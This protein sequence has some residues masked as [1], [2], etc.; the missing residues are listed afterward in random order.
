MARADRIW[1]QFDGRVG[2]TYLDVTLPRWIRALSPL[3]NLTARISASMHAKLLGGFLVVA[4][5]LVGMGLL[6]LGTIEQ[7]NQR[8]QE[9]RRLQDDV[10]RAHQMLYDTTAQMHYRAM[11]LLNA[12]VRHIPWDNED[13]QKIVKAKREFLTNLNY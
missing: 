13:I 8:V 2:W 9:V 5:L 4:L 11:T 12:Q 10:V 7:M 6:S 3:V 1:P